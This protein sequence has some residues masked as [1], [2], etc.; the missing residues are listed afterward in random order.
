ME[1]FYPLQL[2]TLYQCSFSVFDNCTMVVKDADIREAIRVSQLT[3]KSKIIVIILLRNDIFKKKTSSLN[4][5][6]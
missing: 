1:I 2:G 5:A 6:F 3:G 4:K